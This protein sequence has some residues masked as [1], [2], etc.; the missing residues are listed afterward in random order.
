MNIPEHTVLVDR[1]L[2]EAKERLTSSILLTAAAINGLMPIP[3]LIIVVRHAPNKVIPEIGISGTAYDYNLIELDLDSGRI[4]EFESLW[5]HRIL[6]H[7][8][9]HIV[10]MRMIQDPYETLLDAMITEGLAD[11]FDVQ[12]N[13]VVPP[14]WAL[15]LD[16]V[17][18][19]SLL[20]RARNVFSSKN[21]NHNAWFFGEDL[22]TFPRWTGYAIGF[23]LVGKYLA[24]NPG[25]TAAQLVATPAKEF[26][27]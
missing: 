11:W 22:S 21:Y 18:L 4:I 20:D 24:K 12:T 17:A 2:G 3:R 1:K 5:L 26:L 16:D 13:S 6:T 27:I 15:A 10:R 14:P 25:L 7:E 19:H 23:H 8:L 9:H